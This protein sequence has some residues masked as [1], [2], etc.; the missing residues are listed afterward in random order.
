MQQQNGDTNQGWAVRINGEG[1]WDK[2]GQWACGSCPAL[3]LR[4]LAHPVLLLA[5]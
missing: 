5:K 3:D 2:G 1:G 4:V